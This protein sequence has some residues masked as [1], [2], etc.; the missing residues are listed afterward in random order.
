MEAKDSIVVAD[1]K[2]PEQCITEMSLLSPTPPDSLIVETHVANAQLVMTVYVVAEMP[3]APPGESLWPCRACLV[4]ACYNACTQK[5]S[6]VLL[7]S[8]QTPYW[9]RVCTW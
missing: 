2:L 1:R 3:S 8:A 5:S 9:H 4:H 6:S 7:T